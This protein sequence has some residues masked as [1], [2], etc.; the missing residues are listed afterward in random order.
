MKSVLTH[1]AIGSYRKKLLGYKTYVATC[2][3]IPI[4]PF[5]HTFQVR[6]SLAPSQQQLQNNP[7]KKTNPNPNQNMGRGA[8]GSTQP[9]KE[10]KIKD[11]LQKSKLLRL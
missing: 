1:P 2:T 8:F 11:F 7:N 4:P 5:Q 10:K 9:R 6:N 3:P